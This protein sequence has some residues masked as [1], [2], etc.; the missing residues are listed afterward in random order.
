MIWRLLL[1]LCVASPAAAGLFKVWVHKTALATGYQLAREVQATQVLRDQE[2]HLQ[3]ELS[4]LKT[5]ERL[6]DLAARLGLAPPPR[7]RVF[8]GAGDT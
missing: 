3:V 6:K 7:A 4:A 1:A 2:R 5:P 8:S